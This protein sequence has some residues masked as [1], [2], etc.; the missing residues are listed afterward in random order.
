MYVA[1]VAC[2]MDAAPWVSINATSCLFDALSHPVVVKATSSVASIDAL[3]YPI[4]LTERRTEFDVPLMCIFGRL[5]ALHC[6]C[7]LNV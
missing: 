4:H 1:F 5:L 2:N 3:F 7:C 6:Y